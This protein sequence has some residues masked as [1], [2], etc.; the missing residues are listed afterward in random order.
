MAMPVCIFVKIF[1]SRSVT[2]MRCFFACFIGLVLTLNCG[3]VRAIT[4]EEADFISQYKPHFH[5]LEDFYSNIEIVAV[6]TFVVPEREGVSP[7]ILR[8]FLRA[9]G[10]MKTEISRDY[11]DPQGQKQLLTHITTTTPKGRYSFSRGRENDPFDLTSYEKSHSKSH[12]KDNPNPRPYLY[13]I[14]PFAIAPFSANAASLKGYLVEPHFAYE[15]R[16]VKDMI[17]NLTDHTEN[18]IR[19]LSFTT[20]D[21]LAEIK[22]DLAYNLNWAVIKA[23]EKTFPDDVRSARCE[24]LESWA[25]NL[26]IALTQPRPSLVSVVE[27]EGESNGIPLIKKLTRTTFDPQGQIVAQ[28]VYDIL[29]IK[30]GAPPYSVFDPRQ[31]VGDKNLDDWEFPEPRR[32]TPFKIASLIVGI[33]LIIWGLWLHFRK[34]KEK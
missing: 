9:G 23:E 4:D 19:I 15:K 34:Q 29:E 16:T 1:S 10:Y 14:A 21:P 24:S 8:L 22:F 17:S 6:R 27:Y 2:I 7:Q 30:P 12:D 20:L 5:A 13:G 3:A 28:V 31:Y 32:F 25:E 11:F 33:I 18:G 26:R